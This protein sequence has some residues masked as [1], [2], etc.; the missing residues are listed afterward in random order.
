MTQP[1]RLR[2]AL[3]VIAWITAC[4]NSQAASGPAV[5]TYVTIPVANNKTSGNIQTNLVS[6]FPNGIFT[7]NN[8]LATPFDIPG[9]PGDCG[10]S[11]NAP[12]NFFAFLPGSAGS[13][14]TK[15]SERTLRQ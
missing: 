2:A 14:L 1:T 15:W 6:T 8:A 12:C 9:A 11:L 7:A 4:A 13:V 3:I 5:L 10:T